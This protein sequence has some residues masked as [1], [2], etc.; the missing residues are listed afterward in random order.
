[1]SRK[2]QS[3]EELIQTHVLNLTEI[4]EAERKEIHSK[5]KKLPILF[6]ILG[7]LF[8]VTGFCYWKF[9]HPSLEKEDVVVASKTEKNTLTCISNLEYRE[10]NLKVSTKTIYYFQNQGLVSSTNDTQFSMLRKEDSHLLVSYR[11]YYSSIYLNEDPNIIYQISL[12]N[13]V[14]TFS[15]QIQD[16]SQFHLDQYHLEIHQMNHT[17]VYQGGE[18]LTT[19]Q[20]REEKL[21]N[22]CN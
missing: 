18:S 3:Q 5:N 15:S 13:D 16:Y 17:S 6:S 1:M 21:G 11:D 8:I 10:E 9:Y 2:K 14:L 19:I 4:R 22:L 7:V 20:S 12:Q